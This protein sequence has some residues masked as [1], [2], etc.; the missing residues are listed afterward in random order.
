MRLYEIDRRIREILET[1]VDPETGEISERA[2]AE[3]DALEVARERKLEALA[4]VVL[5]LEGDAEAIRKEEKRLEERRRRIER[6]VERLKDYIRQHLVVGETIEGELVSIR[7]RRAKAVE[8]HDL[9]RLPESCVRIRRDP[10]RT[11]IRAAIE[12]G[13]EVPGAELVE[14]F[15][16]V[17]R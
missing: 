7:W 16:L 13:E 4:L 3:L 8:V 2:A 10:D 9:D 6:R 11:A 5:E 17:I 1:E 15:H 14:R 12:R